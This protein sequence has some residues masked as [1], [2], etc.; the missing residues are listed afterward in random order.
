[1]IPPSRLYDAIDATWAPLRRWQDGGWVHRDGAGGGKR[2]S[3]ATAHSLGDVPMGPPPALVMIRQG[4]DALDA[5]LAKAG[6]RIVDPVVLYA[7]PC[8]ALA[9][10]TPPGIRTITTDAPLA[11]MREVWGAGGIGAARLAVMDRAAGP[12]TFL[13]GR[14]ADRTAA[15]AFAALDGEIVMLHALEVAPAARRDG[16]GQDLTAAAARWGRTQG[17][18]CIALM[19]TEANAPARALYE[20]LEMELSGRYHY[21][22]KAGA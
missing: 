8:G 20:G 21:R 12:K 5:A 18:K 2:V 3:A 15:C 7:A 9:E 17:A 22:T 11:R 13:L 10:R 19:T 1:M 6:H 14:S 16:L 4:E